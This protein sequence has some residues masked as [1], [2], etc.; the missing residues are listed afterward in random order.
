MRCYDCD[1]IFLRRG[2]DRKR[3]LQTGHAAAENDDVF[4]LGLGHCGWCFQNRKSGEVWRNLNY[5]IYNWLLDF[6][7][8]IKSSRVL[9][10]KLECSYIGVVNRH[11]FL[12]MEKRTISSQSGRVGY[13]DLTGS[14]Q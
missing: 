11:F 14:C 7:N 5:E 3:G 4:L 9:V 8:G 1:F 6:V 10:E 13:P 12:G 2:E